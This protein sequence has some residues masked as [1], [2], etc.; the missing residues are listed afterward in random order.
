[1]QFISGGEVGGEKGEDKKKIIVA[2]NNS[3]CKDKWLYSWQLAFWA[4]Y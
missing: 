4:T 2:N 3:N 1:M